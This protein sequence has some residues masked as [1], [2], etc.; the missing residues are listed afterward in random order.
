MTKDNITTQD[1]KGVKNKGID[2][3]DIPRKK[4]K[5][6]RP[7]GSKNKKTKEQ[8]MEVELLRE[9]IMDAKDPIFMALLGKALGSQ[10]LFV[11][12]SYKYK[13]KSGKW[14]SKKKKPR[15]IKDDSTIIDYLAGNLDHTDDEYYYITTIDPDT[16]SIELAMAYGYGRP[17]TT[18]DVN[19]KQWS[20]SQAIV[21]V[22]NDLNDDD[23]GAIEQFADDETKR[24]IGISKQA[25]L[26]QNGSTNGD[27]VIKDPESEPSKG[28]PGE[29]KASKEKQVSE[30]KPKDD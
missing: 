9:K 28:G 7:K 11:I 30:E 12:E 1:K 17:K 8:E 13:D 15:L 14:Q 23:Y 19:V 3:P 20:L 5:G 4:L 24:K 16:K 18:A 6:G 26:Q 25:W 21:K 27:E 2:K 29:G 22:V 10:K